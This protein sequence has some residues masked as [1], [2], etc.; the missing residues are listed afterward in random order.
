MPSFLFFKNNQKVFE[1]K[2]ANTE[3]LGR[4][5]Q[6]LAGT[7]S[8]FCYSNANK[9]PTTAVPATPAKPASPYTYFPC[10]AYVFSDGEKLDRVIEKAAEFNGKITVTF[11]YLELTNV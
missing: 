8:C 6:S 3:Q 7:Q 2:G 9:G 4:A 5:L 10:A 1:F 11:N